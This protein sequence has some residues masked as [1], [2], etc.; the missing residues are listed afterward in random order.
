MLGFQP[1]LFY[2]FTKLSDTYTHLN[3]KTLESKGF[4][5]MVS[6]MERKHLQSENIYS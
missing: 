5:L 6:D 1:K 2:R 4:Q 3:L